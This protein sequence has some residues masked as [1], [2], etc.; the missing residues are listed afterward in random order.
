[1]GPSILARLPAGLDALMEQVVVH[2][3][4][5][6]GFHVVEVRD[7]RTYAIE[8]GNEAVIDALPGVPAG[9]SFVGT[10]DREH[11]VENETIDFFASGHPLVEG[12]LAHFEE[13]PKGRVGRLE[14]RLPGQDG[15][16]LIVIYKD[17]PELEVVALDAEGG[18]RRDWADAF[19]HSAV[20][21]QRMAPDDVAAHDW[22]TVVT[23]LGAS[24]GPRRPHAIAAV[25]VK[26]Q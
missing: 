2:A 5:G 10:F 17:G 8:F 15:T 20:R 24:L 12:L 9:A 25:V 3:A 14:V 26:G 21:A 1:M 16:G 13:D 7:C 22:A 23:R 18:A 19:T 6:L 11:A 4:A